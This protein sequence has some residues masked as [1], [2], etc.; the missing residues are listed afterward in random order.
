MPLQCKTL[1]G[2]EEI[3]LG[4]E[5]EQKYPSPVVSKRGKGKESAKRREW[6]RGEAQK[7]EFLAS[8]KG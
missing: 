2:A 1:K 8:K 7:P 5:E 4:S 6:R 3:I